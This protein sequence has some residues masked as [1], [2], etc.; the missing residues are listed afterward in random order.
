MPGPQRVPSLV[1]SETIRSGQESWRVRL[2]MTQMPGEPLD[3][4]LESWRRQCA[5]G[6][7]SHV[8]QSCELARQLLLQLCPTFEN[9]SGLAYHRDVNAHNILIEGGWEGNA[10]YGLVDFG[11][12]VDA[13]CWQSEDNA[14]AAPV[15]PTRVGSDGSCTWHHLDVGG[16]CRYWPVSAWLQFLLGWREVSASPALSVEYQTR[17]DLHALGIT[18]IQIIAESLPPMPE[19]DGAAGP[20]VPEEMWALQ[21]AWE[22]YWGR[23][24]PLHCQL[25]D[26]FTKNGDWDALKIEYI[27]GSVHTVVADDLRALRSALRAAGEACRRAPNAAGVADAPGLFAALLALVSCGDA[28][29]VPL[30]VPAGVSVGPRQWREVLRMLKDGRPEKHDARQ[31]SPT[32]V[33]RT[34]VRG[35]SPSPIVQAQ[36]APPSTDLLRKIN[37]LSDKVDRLANAMARLEDRGKEEDVL[38]H[39]Q[40]L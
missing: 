39:G 9:I 33:R 25:V 7:R 20:D 27:T 10:S 34:E 2:A 19:P 12:A 14:G 1:A 30:Q 11:L 18:G 13:Q 40:I 28:D 36:E 8:A 15:R 16:D 23:V 3:L 4:F 31:R 21:R 5:A 26:T 24:L 22:R 38:S 6:R 29:D 35:R 32:P 17:L 37:Q